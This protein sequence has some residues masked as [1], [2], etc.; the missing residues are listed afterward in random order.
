MITVSDEVTSVLAGSYR[1]RLA[2]ESWRDGELLHDSV[3]VDAATEET[4]RGDRVPE[5]I[6]LTVP[7]TADGV[8]W[9]PTGEDHPLAANGQ[10]LRVQLGIG[11][12]NGT[13][14]WFQRGWFVIKDSR[15]DGD[16]VTVEAVGL[17]WL[18]EEARFVSPFQPSGTLVSTLRALIEPALTVVVDP[19]LS[20][21]SVPAGVN[22]DEDRL[23]ALMELLDAWPADYR[24][25]EDGYLYVFPPDQPAT[26]VLALSDGYGGTVIEATGSSS[27]DEA[28]N[29]VVALGTDTNGG[30]VLGTAYDWSGANRYGGPFNPLPVPFKFA[31]PLLTTVAQCTAA[32]QTRLATLKRQSGREFQVEMVPN[33]TLQVGDV[34]SVT[35]ADYA[36]LVCVIEALKL[37]YTADGGSMGLT[38]RSLT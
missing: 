36:G 22:W 17:L 30:Q 32:A 33:P 19:G 20:D 37:P 27:R 11:V 2:V 28:F 10:M 14:E 29:V 16:A 9:A 1:L 4:R 6:T 38:V 8:S 7:R 31:S 26:P 35:A 25:T 21:R 3:P 12:G 34:V 24:V 5:R 13:T 18:V 15:A 23:G